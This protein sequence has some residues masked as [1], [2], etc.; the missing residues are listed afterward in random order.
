MSQMQ[1]D[2]WRFPMPLMCSAFESGMLDYTLAQMPKDGFGAIAHA[3][4]FY[5]RGLPDDACRLAEPYLTSEDLSLRLSAC[6][7]CAYANLSLNRS[8]AARR[9]LRH[10]EETGKDPRVTENP[11]ARASYMLFAASA[12]VLL[13]FPSPV[14]REE[15]NSY[16][17]LLPEGLRLFATY[18]L[19]HR[20]Y[21][22]GDYGRC[23]G[24]AENALSM[25]QGSYPVAEIF[26]HLI[27]A[28]GWIN[29]H[30]T[31][32]AKAHF[33]RAWHIA[34][35]DDLIEML[36]EHHGLLQGV[37]ESCLK[38]DFPQDLARII[39]ITDRF[40]R[41]WRSVHN[42]TAGASVADNLTTTEFAISMLACRGW[43]NDEIAAH[44]QISRGTVK[45]RLSSAYA[46]LGISSRAALR[47]F[48]L[49]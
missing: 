33:V 36:G 27:T 49:L 28:V 14:S 22:E 29:Q 25:K 20:S 6:L 34:Q 1:D 47:Q 11:R 9:C 4:A 41:R 32:R 5:Y 38:K 35:L 26:L 37:L 18:A 48:M 7:I 8:V 40:S 3:E 17:A 10:L 30:D 23:V 13:H 12:C 44:L 42:P 31:D 24:M 46:K 16:A 19:A 39:K 2:S 43:T 21:L 15:F 45:N